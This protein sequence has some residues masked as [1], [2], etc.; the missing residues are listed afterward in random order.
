M[1][2][3]I[4]GYEVD[5][6]GIV[7]GEAVP[8][9]IPGGPILLAFAEAGLGDDGEAIADVRQRV[10]KELG[11][12]AI[13]DAAAV[14]ANFQRMVRIADGTGIPLDDAVASVTVDLRD[15]LRLNDY[16]TARLPREAG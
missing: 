6:E 10:G 12:R 9:G 5:L 14:I 16:P 4:G 13:V 3:R 8:T 1:S 2:A 7:A 15:E 11:E